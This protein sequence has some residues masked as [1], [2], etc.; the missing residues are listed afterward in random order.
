MGKWISNTNVGLC[1]AVVRALLRTPAQEGLGSS[2]VSA[3]D[4]DSC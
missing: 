3:S 2:P 1:G 4:L